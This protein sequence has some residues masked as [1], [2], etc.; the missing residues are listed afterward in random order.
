MTNKTNLFSLFLPLFFLMALMV[1]AL[2]NYPTIFHSATSGL[3]IIFVALVLYTVLWYVLKPDD[4]SRKG[5]LLIGVLFIINIT[6]EDFVDWHT[7]TGRLVSTL[8]M[9]VAIFLCFA[10]IS[11]V[12][13][14]RSGNILLGLKSSFTSALSGTLIALCFGFLICYV[15]EEKMLGILQDDRGYSDFSNPKE[16]VFF[17]AFDNASS[18]VIIAP[19]VS[20]LMG[21][22]GGGIVLIIL[23]FKKPTPKFEK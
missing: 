16:F 4:F 7:Q 2:I 3:I 22:L 10:I 19:V 18:H 14:Y 11:G 13:T 15:F 17:N 5:G 6:I 8:S 23:R 20:L 9:M 21:A 12:K 1:I